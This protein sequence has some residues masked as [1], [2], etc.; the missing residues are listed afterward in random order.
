MGPD[1]HFDLMVTRNAELRAE[2]A[3]HRRAREVIAAR[4][5]RSDGERRRG[6]NLFRK[7]S[8]A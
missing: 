8:A 4:K 2:A 6:L 5:N 1:I 7:T 3:E